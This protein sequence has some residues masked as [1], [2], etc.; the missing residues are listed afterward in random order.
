MTT[1]IGED[2]SYELVVPDL[3][4]TADIQVALRLLSYGTSSDPADDKEIE[5]TSIAGYF[6]LVRTAAGTPLFIQPTPTNETATGTLLASELLGQ[7]ITANISAGITLT[8]PTGSNIDLEL[9]APQRAPQNNTAF[10]W[11]LINQTSATHAVT[12]AQATG[13]TIVGST[14]IP[15]NTSALFRTRKTATNTYVSYRLS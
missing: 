12:L 15:A 7:I 4:D 13:H 10:D 6:K 1:P 3:S 2:T 5:P 11:H 14:S 9:G 8:L